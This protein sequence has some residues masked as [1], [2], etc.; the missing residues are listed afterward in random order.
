MTAIEKARLA[1]RYVLE[2]KAEDV[3][4]LNVSGLTS[5]TDYFLI[6]SCSST[7]QVQAV[8]RHLKERMKESGISPL[9]VEGE[10]E[11]HWVLLDYGDLVVH[12]FYEPL[13]RY[14]DLEGLWIEAPMTKV[15]NEV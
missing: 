13:R 14:Y 6:M 12:V 9:G 4:M 5:L 2:R 8:S 15:P 7:R 10:T 11:G 1:A 3:I